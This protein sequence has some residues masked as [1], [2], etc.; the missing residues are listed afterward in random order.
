MFLLAVMSCL[1]KTARGGSVSFGP[2]FEGYR[3]SQLRKPGSEHG[4]KCGGRSIGSWSHSVCSED[5]ERVGSSASF[6]LGSDAVWG[7]GTWDD[8][9]HSQGGA[10]LQTVMTL[11]RTCMTKWKLIRPSAN[12]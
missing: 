10:S 11:R 1:V 9:A 2:R 6:D 12:P 4:S 5:K 7:H 3:S 8:A